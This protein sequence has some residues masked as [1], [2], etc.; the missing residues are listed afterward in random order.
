MAIVDGAAELRQG[1]PLSADRAAGRAVTAQRPAA[2]VWRTAALS[3][4]AGHRS[5]PPALHD[6]RRS[7]QAARAARNPIFRERRGTRES[8]ACSKP[9]TATCSSR[10]ITTAWSCGPP[11]YFFDDPQLGAV[12]DRGDD[13]H[14]LTASQVAGRPPE[15]I[16]DDERSKAKK[17]NFGTI[18]GI[19][20]DQPRCADLEELPPRHQPRRTPRTCSPGSPASIR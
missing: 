20:A 6:R 17:V 10:P 2:V 8:V 18:Y 13:P 11:A 14:K 9:R 1:D 15:E 16:T 12:F 19:G 4:L 7:D 5:R 3:R